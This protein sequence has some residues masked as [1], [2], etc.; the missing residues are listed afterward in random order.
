MDAI[1]SKKE[2]LEYYLQVQDEY[3]KLPKE[4]KALF[5][6][7]RM[8]LFVE[9]EDVESIR[10]I[11]N[12]FKVVLTPK[13]SDMIDGMKLFELCSKISRDISIRYTKS[14][15]EFNVKNQKDN[16]QKVIQLLDSLDKVNKD[17]NR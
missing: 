1:D 15:L 14:K 6:K 7:K 2:L 9:L 3:G 13:R 5:D 8:S 12:E 17:E 16:I 11:N 4:V 10:V